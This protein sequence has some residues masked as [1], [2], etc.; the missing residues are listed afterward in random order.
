MRSMTLIPLAGAALALEP[1]L[2][3]P[4]TGAGDGWVVAA[5]NRADF[6]GKQGSAGWSYLFDRGAGTVVEPMPFY[7]SGSGVTGWCTANQIGG[8]GSYCQIARASS[9]EIQMHP[10]APNS[11]SLTGPGLQRPV[12]R[13]SSGVRTEARIRL[14]AEWYATSGH[15]ARLTLSANGEVLFDRT[16]VE[17]GGKPILVEFAVEDLETLELLEDPTSDG[18]NSDAVKVHLVVL[19]PDCDANGIAD[20]VEIA[21][22]SVVDD[23]GDGVPDACQ[24]NGDVIQNGVVD[25]ADLSAVLAV[26][27]TDGGLY[28]RADTNGDGVVD[29]QDL[30]TV[31]GGWGLCGG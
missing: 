28:P 11:C 29:G 9:G 21:D 6:S 20:I 8:S 7:T 2:A 31:L 22:G 12:L 3:L 19:A 5:D 4:T 13:W 17:I 16:L 18:C 24:C 15:D 1:A 23:D 27:G 26:W 25:G 14:S 30:A 10:N